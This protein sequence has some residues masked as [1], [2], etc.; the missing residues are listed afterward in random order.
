MGGSLSATVSVTTGGRPATAE[1]WD[2]RA[3]TLLSEGKQREAIAAYREAVTAYPDLQG[4]I[5]DLA[6]QYKTGNLELAYCLDPSDKA[7][8]AAWSKAGSPR[9]ALCAETR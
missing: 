7:L 5:K 4:R 1:E 9:H 8:A 2:R 6:G 3:A